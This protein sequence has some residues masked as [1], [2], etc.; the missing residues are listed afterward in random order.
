MARRIGPD[1]PD[2]DLRM[3]GHHAASRTGRVGVAVVPARRAGDYRT[4]A[5]IG[6]AVLRLRGFIDAFGV[7][8]RVRAE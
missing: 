4:G 7:K 5:T 2:V 3:R 6:N 1:S 8:L